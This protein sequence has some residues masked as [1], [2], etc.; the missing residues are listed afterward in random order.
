MH[1]VCDAYG[2]A[3]VRQLIQSGYLNEDSEKMRKQFRT[4]TV[5]VEGRCIIRAAIKNVW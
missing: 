4:I 3:A 5:I 2:G 1:R